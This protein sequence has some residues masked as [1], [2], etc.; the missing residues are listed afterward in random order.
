MVSTPPWLNEL[1]AKGVDVTDQTWS[2]NVNRTS[3]TASS[4]LMLINHFLDSVYNLAGTVFYIPN[5]ELLNETNAESGTGS[6]GAHVTNCQSIW[7][8]V[9]S[10]RNREACCAD[11]QT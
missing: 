1:L 10:L 7:G 8:W 2:C 11:E 6:I 4:Q 9:H 3:G 5:T